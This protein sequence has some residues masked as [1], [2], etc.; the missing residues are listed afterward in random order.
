MAS[1]GATDKYDDY[2]NKY[3]DSINNNNNNSA[4]REKKQK[5]STNTNK[6]INKLLQC[7]IN[8]FFADDIILV[9]IWFFVL[10]LFSLLHCMI[11]ILTNLVNTR[12]FS[13]T[14][15]YFVSMLSN[16][17][18]ISSNL[19]LSMH[20]QK[21]SVPTRLNQYIT[22]K[23]TS[24]V[25]CWLNVIVMHMLVHW[26]IHRLE[27]KLFWWKYSTV[28]IK[29]VML[30]GL[31]NYI[32]HVINSMVNMPT[33]YIYIHVVL[34]LVLPFAVSLL[35]K[36]WN[37]LQSKYGKIPMPSFHSFFS[38]YFRYKWKTFATLNDYCQMKHSI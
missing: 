24:N 8:I 26:K 4:N 29:S 19:K 17:N 10:P 28:L 11:V 21:E 33:L 5:Q 9:S 32:F 25:E 38:C 12:S 15:D 31:L 7:A 6:Q 20:F 34:S 23:Y 36:M 3:F 37:S 18:T 22:I 27:Y 1:I 16:Y 13:W 14:L 2:K 35:A 30:G